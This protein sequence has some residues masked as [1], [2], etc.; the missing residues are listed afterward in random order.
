MDSARYLPDGSLEISPNDRFAD[1]RAMSGHPAPGQLA[2][3]LGIIRN[4]ASTSCGR[5]RM[6]RRPVRKAGSSPSAIRR[7]NVSLLIPL[8]SAAWVNDSYC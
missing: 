8:R 3:Y 5:T 7:H 2:R 6:I 1:R 4:I